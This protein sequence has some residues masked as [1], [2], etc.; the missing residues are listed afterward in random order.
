[1]SGDFEYLL[2]DIYSS[3]FRWLTG[4]LAA[5]IIAGVVGIGLSFSPKALRPISVGFDFLRAVPILAIVPLVL[6]YWGHSE[7][8]K[9][10]IVFFA[11]F[12]P[13]VVSVLL[14]LRASSVDMK[15]FYNGLGLP[16]VSLWR[17]SMAPLI[18]SGLRRGAVIAIGIGWISVVAAE[19]LGIPSLDYFNGG[20]GYRIYQFQDTGN[21]GGMWLYAAIFGVLGLGSGWVAHALV[22]EMRAEGD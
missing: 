1:M 3:T 2:V 22:H 18:L 9:V 6:Y 14:S 15:I 19:L 5:I 10:F 7:I 21:I 20:L 12:F 11:C 13:I 4:F 8:A 16:A 17:I